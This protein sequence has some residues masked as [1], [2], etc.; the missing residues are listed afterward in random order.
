MRMMTPMILLVER[1]LAW[2][3]LMRL[4][5]RVFVLSIHLHEAMVCSAVYQAMLAR[6]LTLIIHIERIVG[7]YL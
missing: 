4:V 1:L 2:V 6:L 3:L 5:L 7:S